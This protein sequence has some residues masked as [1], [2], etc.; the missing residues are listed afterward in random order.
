MFNKYIMVF[1]KPIM[2]F[3]LISSVTQY[4]VNKSE[5]AILNN[6]IETLETELNEK[7][8]RLMASNLNEK[9]LTLEIEKINQRVEKERIDTRRRSR[10]YAKAMSKK[11]VSKYIAN[12]TKDANE[13]KTECDNLNSILDNVISIGL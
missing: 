6:A 8:T 7:S 12:Y 1:A 9:T 3:L 11:A 2:I 10:A 4:F 13:S 5:V